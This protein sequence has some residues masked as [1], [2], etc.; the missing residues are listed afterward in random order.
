MG[1]AVAAARRSMSR[2]SSSNHVSDDWP[3]ITRFLVI[4]KPKGVG[5]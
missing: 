4:E 2:G 3:P 1:K 5:T